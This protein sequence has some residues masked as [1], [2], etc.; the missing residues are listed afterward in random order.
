MAKKYDVAVMHD[1]FVDRLV[2]AGD[3]SRLAA[4]VSEKAR[5]G[6]GGIHDVE[7]VEVAGGNAVNLARALA[8]LGVKTLLITHSDKQHRAL[9]ERL[10]EGTDAE[11]RIKGLPAGL[12]VAFEGE[13]NVM[14]GH[15]GGAGDFSASTLDESDWVALK[16]ARVVCSV[17][18]A[19]NIRGTELLRELRKGLG[20]KKRIFLNPADVRDRTDRLPA[21]VSAIASERVADWLSVNEFEAEALAKALSL[22]GG[23]G[24]GVCSRL[25]GALGIRVDVHTERASYT[26]SA[27]SVA[28]APCKWR[29]PNRLTGAGDVWDAAS[30]YCDLDGK[31]DLERL[32]FA[33]AAAALFVGAEDPR[34][35]TVAE[36]EASY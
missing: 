11:L 22:R 31:S 23:S 5:A 14:L 13:V 4:A 30:I 25:S 27:G 24:P 10:F 19:A 28:D 6:G 21:L 7:Q 34:P 36:V 8:E 35:P 1:Y 26:S 3:V 9:L 32:R 12:T 16:S 17:N 15:L 20:P 2:R 33:N 18:W 29:E